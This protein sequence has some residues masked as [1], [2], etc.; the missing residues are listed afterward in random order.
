M[1]VSAPGLLVQG[2]EFTCC[3][4]CYKGGG[5]AGMEGK[6]GDSSYLSHA[7]GAIFAMRDWCCNLWYQKIAGTSLCLQAGK[8]S[9]TQ[10]LG[11]TT[12]LLHVVFSLF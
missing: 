8:Y 7:A 3:C 4:C 6:Q 2:C 1:T 11:S 12:F 5:T 9:N 10:C